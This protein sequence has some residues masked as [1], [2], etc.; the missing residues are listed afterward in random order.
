MRTHL[1]H[2]T[3]AALCI[4]TALA[5]FVERAAATPV[6]TNYLTL[7]SG[8]V[9][10]RASP[11]AE[12][13]AHVAFD[14]S[15]QTLT[16]G[17]PKKEPLPLSIVVE[18]PAATTFS[19]FQVPVFNEF[20]AARGRHIR[21]LRIEG[22]SV[23]ADDGFALLAEA[24]IAEGRKAP[25]AFPVSSQVAVRWVRVTFVD[26]LTPSTGPIDGHNFAELEGYGTQA[27]IAT[28]AD[29]FTGRWRY[30]RKGLN[31]SPGVNVI[32]LTQSGQDV[33]GCRVV[34]GQ[35][36]TLRGTIVD[37]LARLVAEDLDKKKRSP[38]TAI[39]TA[40]GHLSGVDFDGP[41]RAFHAAHDPS[42]KPVC[43]KPPPAN[44]VAAALG[45]GAPVALY[46]IHFDV[47]SDVLRADAEPA[48]GQLQEALAAVG[49]LAVVIEGHTDSDG[50]DADNLDLSLRRAR[51]VMAWLIARGV[52]A[53]RLTAEGRGES[54]PIADNATSSGRALNRRVEVA[55]R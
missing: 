20:G 14:G 12:M 30:R 16:I 22:S 37:G 46:G 15:A 28:K 9:V 17:V 42:A 13:A 50:G 2:T 5:A 34:G 45:E 33:A 8:A 19:R 41:A 29:A 44:P 26:R 27:P 51:S 10:V 53:G 38:F 40:G 31:D 43:T 11:Q 4:P 21:T 3:L 35:M 32:E 49:A 24:E 55:P 18:L 23:S 47:A 54:R 39:V 1:L 52:P 7:G 25:Q 48:L 6:E 36:Q